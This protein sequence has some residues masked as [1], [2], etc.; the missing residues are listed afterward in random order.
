MRVFVEF[1]EG[2]KIAVGA[3]Q[4]NKLR[5]FLTLLGIIVGVS[6]VIG[7]ISLT[8]GLDEAFGDQISALGSDVLYVQKYPWFDREGWEKYRNRSSR[9]SREICVFSRLSPDWK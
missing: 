1:W 6:T 4:A 5:A 9:N 2:L 8:D 7:I 3:L